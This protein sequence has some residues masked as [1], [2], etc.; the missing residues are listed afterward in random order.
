[1]KKEAFLLVVIGLILSV[2]LL[3]LTLVYNT[4]TSVVV[5]IYSLNQTAASFI[6]VGDANTNATLRGECGGGAGSTVLI[7]NTLTWD[8]SLGTENG[9]DLGANATLN[10]TNQLTQD[11]F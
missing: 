6:A 5:N 11:F 4:S 9:T 10:L 1:M 8:I 3:N 7:L 2:C